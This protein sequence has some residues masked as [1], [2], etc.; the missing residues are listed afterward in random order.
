MASFSSGFSNSQTTSNPNDK[1]KPKQARKNTANSFLSKAPSTEVQ[2]FKTLAKNHWQLV[3]LELLLN[4]IDRNN[5]DSTTTSSMQRFDR[6]WNQVD[7]Q[8]AQQIAQSQYAAKPL[9][10]DL[11]KRFNSL[12]SKHW[13]NNLGDKNH[14]I[15][16]YPQLSSNE[17]IALSGK[18]QAKQLKRLDERPSEKTTSKGRSNGIRSLFQSAGLEGP[19]AV[20]TEAE[21]APPCELSFSPDQLRSEIEGLWQYLNQN[22]NARHMQYDQLRYQFNA[23]LLSQTPQVG[24]W[25]FQQWQRA[26]GPINRASSDLMATQ[27]LKK[28]CPC[29]ACQ[30]QTTNPIR[31]GT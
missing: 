19:A 13:E 28:L 1:N 3:E 9:L 27:L 12:V 18:E 20:E 6:L 5:A 29:P 26:P 8:M 23:P 15:N 17:A 21:L 16:R 24:D 7:G 25:L 4:Q 22:P 11:L 10:D 2:E 31:A 14:P 30:G